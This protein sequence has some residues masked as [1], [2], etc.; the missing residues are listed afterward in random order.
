MTPTAVD[1]VWTDDRMIE[2]VRAGV[3]PPGELPRLLAGWRAETHAM[4]MRELVD[5]DTAQ[6]IITARRRNLRTSLRSL[7]RYGRGGR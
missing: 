2:Q 3:I 6:R 5:V 7:L 4:L 1:T